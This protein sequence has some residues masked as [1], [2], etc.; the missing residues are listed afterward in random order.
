MRIAIIG[1][2]FAG[3]GMAIRLRQAGMRDF[4]ILERAG[5]LGGTWRDN[6]YPG[7]QCDIPSRLYSFSFAL[8]PHWSRTFPTQPEILDYLHRVS[9]QHGVDEHI[10]YH[11]EVLD[12]AWDDARA[13]WHIDTAQGPVEAQ[14]LISAV[15]G[16]SEPSIPTLPGMGAFTGTSF[17]SAQWDHEHDLRGRRVAVIGTGASAIQFVPRIQ[18]L[19]ERLHVFQRTPPW[20]MPHPDRPVREWERTLYETV[21]LA[22]RL[23][24]AGIYWGRETY[25]V[26]FVVNPRV[27]QLAERQ[28]LRHM[29]AQVA[30]EAL[31][32]KL[33]PQ[34]AMGCKR[35]LISNDYYPALQ[36]PNVELVSS[37][38]EEIRARS[39]VTADGVERHVDTIIHGTGFQAAETPVSRRVR[40]LHGIVLSDAWRESG[41]QAY[42]GTTV[43]GFPNLFFI[44]GPNV[45]L[46]HSSMVFMIESQVAYIVDCL[47][48]MERDRLATVEVRTDAQHEYNTGLKRRLGGTVWASGC[49]SWY[50]DGKGRNVALWPGFTYPFRLMTRRFDAARYRLRRQGANAPAPARAAAR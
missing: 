46:G 39:I 6:S 21:P 25:A 22:Q 7:C 18:P 49:R 44:V 37:G 38:I 29:H 8:E 33:T 32:E 15:G 16:L 10:R 28:A 23:V 40:G 9:A 34:Y 26:G 41:A 14:V 35:I 47:R 19:V 42:K 43:A 3:I 24:R 2:G 31:R 17:H 36:K 13:C 48:T 30:D 45:G 50:M 12:A 27:L 20:V 11:H 5:D 4:V 1:S